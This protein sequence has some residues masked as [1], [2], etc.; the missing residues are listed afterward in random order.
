[1]TKEEIARL[2]KSLLE[3]R[4]AVI[5]MTCVILDEKERIVWYKCVSGVAE[6]INFPTT[7]K[8]RKAAEEFF[9]A[10]GVPT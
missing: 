8:G 2:A 3:A 1:M 9:D 4:P 5:P 7:L 6:A 10:A